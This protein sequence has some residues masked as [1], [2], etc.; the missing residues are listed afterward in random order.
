MEFFATQNRVHAL[1]S[2]EVRRLLWGVLFE[3]GRCIPSQYRDAAPTLVPAPEHEQMLLGT[4]YGLL[5][6]EC[7]KAPQLVPRYALQLLEQALALR[8]HTYHC[9][10]TEV[11]EYVVRLVVHVESAVAFV[12]ALGQSGVLAVP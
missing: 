5:L 1:G 2:A 4:P 12:L 10:T 8:T 11:I 6:N 3:P 9:K 7:A